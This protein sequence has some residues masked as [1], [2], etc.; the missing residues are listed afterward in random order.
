FGDILVTT[1]SVPMAPAISTTQ[2]H[3]DVERFRC[4]LQHAVGDRNILV[5]QLAPVVAARGQRRLDVRIAKLCEGRFVDL[6]IATARLCQG[7]KSL[8]KRL[9]RV[10]PEL[11]HITV[12]KCENRGVATAEMQRARTRNCDL[13]KQLRLVLEKIEVGDIDRMSPAHATFYDG[14]RLCATP[15]AVRRALSIGSR[16]RV[17][18]YVA[19]LLIEKA[20]IRPAT[21]LT[22]G[23]KLQAQGLLQRHSFCDRGIFRSAQIGL[24]NFSAREASATLKKAL[25]P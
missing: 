23:D 12:G 1:L 22:V 4:R 9:D 3:P 21:E 8:A 14:D 7:G 25:R 18:A 13:G 24:R 6:D 16:D 11:I 17:D 10:I 5:D 19:K 20:V 2:M 15:A